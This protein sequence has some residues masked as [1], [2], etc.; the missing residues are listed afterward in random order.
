MMNDDQVQCMLCEQWFPQISN[1]HLKHKHSTTI[2]QYRQQFP[3]AP[4]ASNREIQRRKEQATARAEQT[5]GK[6]RSEETKQ[7]MRATKAANPRPAWNKGIS[8]TDEQKAHAS[9]LMKAKYASGELQHWNVGRKW[10]DDIKAKISTTAKRAQRHM[11]DEQKAKRLC[12]YRDKLA[13]G[14]VHPSKDPSTRQKARDTQILRYGMESAS[15]RHLSPEV[16]RLIEDPMWLTEQHITLEKPITQ[17]CTELG[18][19]WKNSNKLIKAR[20]EKYGIEQ[21]YHFSTSYPERELQALLENQGIRVRMN[22]RDVIAPKELDLYLPEYGLAIEY[23]G[24]V[25]H[26]EKFLS[27][28]YHANK[29]AACQKAGVRLITIFEDEWIHRRSIVEEMLL[30]R[31]GRSTRTKI[32][33]RQTSVV[34]ILSNDART[35]HNTYH[36]QGAAY[37]TVGYGLVD[38]EGSFRAVM[39]FVR[40]RTEWVLTR[41]SSSGVVGGFTRLLQ[42]FIRIHCPDKIISFADLRWSSGEVYLKSGFI[43]DKVLPADYSYINSTDRTRIHKFNMRRRHL[44]KIL[45]S[46]DPTKSEWENMQAHGHD[47]IWDCG[48]LRVVWTKEKPG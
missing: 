40:Q 21:Q 30:H 19:H 27:P 6:P 45:P 46:F 48:K 38:S 9:A 8:R 42:H 47:R 32:G 35:F 41:Y 22:V 28:Q 3:S 20:L 14:Y 13:S 2:A 34:P 12:T 16:L 31:V 44:E 29:Y 18:L 5:R 7:K 17:I 33:A 37:Q 1:S 36:I 25:W 24:L 23:C 39:S 43:V 11:S 26:G 4:L 15:Q 10:D